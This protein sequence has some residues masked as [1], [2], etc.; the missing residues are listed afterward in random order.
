MKHKN[1]NKS[2]K[3]TSLYPFRESNAQSAS[4]QPQE[5]AHKN[6]TGTLEIHPNKNASCNELDEAFIPPYL[7]VPQ[8]PTPAKKKDEDIS[9]IVT[10]SRHVLMGKENYGSSL[11]SDQTLQR[12]MI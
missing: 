3:K 6:T 8:T 10:I 9:I 2:K 7:P 5:L 11:S 1:D 12:T 4:T